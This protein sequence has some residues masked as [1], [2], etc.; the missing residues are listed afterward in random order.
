MKIFLASASPAEIRWAVAHGLADGVLTTPGALAAERPGSDPRELL[1]EICRAHPLP[2]LA[3]VPSVDPQDIHREGREL[4]KLADNVV[5]AVPLVDEAVGAI[6]RLAAEGVRVGATLVFSAPQALLAAKAGAS[7][8][9]VPIDQLDA[10]GNESS[11]AVGEV[12]ALFDRGA[13]E[14]DLLAAFPATG[15][16][17]TRCGLA[18][19]DAVAVTPAMMRSLLVH[20]LTDRGIDAFLRELSTRG[21]PRITSV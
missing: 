13:I 9:S 21:K 14:C 16:S 12:R 20:P 7:M 10:L 19:A 3:S 2:V 15:S 1:G 5:L 18:G 4:A 17:L 11:A 8:V 6:R